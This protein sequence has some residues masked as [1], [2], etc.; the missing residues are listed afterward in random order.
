M[1]MHT[2]PCCC[3]EFDRSTYSEGQHY[4]PHCFKCENKKCDRVIKGR[5]AVNEKGKRECERCVLGDDQLSHFSIYQCMC[6]FDTC[7]HH[8][9][10]VESEMIS[11]KYKIGKSIGKCEK[12]KK[13]I[14]GK[15]KHAKPETGPLKGKVYHANCFTCN[16]CKKEIGSAPYAYNGEVIVCQECVKKYQQ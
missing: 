3:C 16:D 11:I 2:V 10:R 6:M 12:C 5:Y 13:V 9:I 7:H 4:H 1:H 15:V 14:A 8:I